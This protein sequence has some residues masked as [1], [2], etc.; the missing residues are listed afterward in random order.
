M[1]EGTVRDGRRDEVRDGFEKTGRRGL[2]VDI[3]MPPDKPLPDRVV[4]EF[5]TWVQQGAAWPATSSRPFG[6]Q[7]HWAFEPVRPQAVPLPDDIS[8]TTGVW[9]LSECSCSAT[10]RPMSGKK[11]VSSS[12]KTRAARWLPFAASANTAF[13]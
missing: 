3:K 9:H 7:K 4:A 13:H 12:W 5:V 1:D 6:G 8:F 2:C 11:V 10:W